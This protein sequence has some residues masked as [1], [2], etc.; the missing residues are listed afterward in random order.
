MTGTI[1]WDFD[2]TLFQTRAF[3]RAKLF[4]AYEPMGVS[5]E[6][7]EEAF[8]E[9]T[10]VSYDYFV[11]DAVLLSL[12][13]RT[14]RT[15]EELAST[16]ERI[17]YTDQGLPF[18]FPHAL[19]AVASAKEKGYM[20]YLLSYGDEPFKT[21]WFSALLLGELFT[22]EEI[23]ISSKKK[24]ELLGNLS[25]S[26]TVIVVN[27]VPAE[28]EAMHEVLVGMGKEV[29]AYLFAPTSAT[30][31]AGSYTVFSDFAELSSLL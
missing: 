2:N 8:K 4:P 9:A 17:V 14:G 29:R 21:R 1:L 23:V 6:T 12:E 5:P 24:P 25:L 3:W 15:K 31:P 7:V 10:S 13:K 27:D 11:P 30:V 26:D 16:L 20:Q 22:P 19:E 28:T 18:F